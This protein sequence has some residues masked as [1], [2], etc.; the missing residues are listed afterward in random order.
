MQN[1]R[2]YGSPPYTIAV[3]HGGPGAAGEM[4]PVAKVISEYCGVLEPMQTKSSISGQAA[5]IHDILSK[6]AGFPVTLAGHS[7]G[8]WLSLIYAAEQPSAVKKIILISSGPFEQSYAAGIQSERMKRLKKKDVDEIEFLMDAIDNPAARNRDRIFT[9]IGEI[10]SKTDVL[11]PVS[12]S[13][14]ASD[15]GRASSDKPAGRTDAPE[16]IELNGSI[17]QS[18][19]KEAEEMRKNGRLLEAARKVKCPVIAIHGDYDP[20]PAAGVE[21]PLSKAVKDFRFILLKKCGHLPW[22]E[23]QAREEFFEILKNEI[24]L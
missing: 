15:F 23:K 7:W 9:R 4:A 18:V 24:L 11:D 17:Y 19:W 22:L 1:P 6:N 16:K 13:G 3:I 8:A 21:K 14:K 2:K 12:A 10:M 5:E 20:H